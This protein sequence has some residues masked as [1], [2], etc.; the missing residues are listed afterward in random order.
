MTLFKIQIKETL[1][2]VVEIEAENAKEAEEKV[3]EAYE[4]NEIVL[5]H[6]NLIRV[7]FDTLITVDIDNIKGE[8]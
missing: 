1:I 4:R 8:S 2:K 7:D 5:E 6:N 3:K